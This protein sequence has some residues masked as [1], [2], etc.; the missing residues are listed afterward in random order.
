MRIHSAAARGDSAA[1]LFEHVTVGHN[2]ALSN[3]P[4]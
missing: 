1:I 2:G 3:Y 4:E